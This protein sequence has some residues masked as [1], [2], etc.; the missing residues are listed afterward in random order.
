VLAIHAGRTPSDGR[1][2][3]DAVAALT[4]GYVGWDLENVVRKAA[5]RAIEAGR[6]GI[7][8]EDL[9]AAVPLVKPWLTPEMTDGY[10]RI[11][12]ADC[13]HHYNF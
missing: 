2:D 7:A 11:H 5:L 3:L 4:E 6:D 1:L 10:R 9:V 13:P 8:Q 12:A